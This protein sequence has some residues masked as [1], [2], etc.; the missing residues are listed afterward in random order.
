[1]RNILSK[2][3]SDGSSWKLAHIYVLKLLGDRLHSSLVGACKNDFYLIYYRPIWKFDP[4]CGW[5]LVSYT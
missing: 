5:Q 3:F 1:M 2:Y 4:G